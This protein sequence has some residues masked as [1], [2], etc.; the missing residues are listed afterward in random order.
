MTFDT[1]NT[2]FDNVEIHAKN[3]AG[4]LDSITSGKEFTPQAPATMRNNGPTTDF[5][6]TGKGNKEEKDKINHTV[7]YN[8]NGAVIGIPGGLEAII[9]EVVSRLSTRINSETVVNGGSAV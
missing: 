6:G 8:Q 5:S 3:A 9:D 2:T 1:L 7:I 4:Y